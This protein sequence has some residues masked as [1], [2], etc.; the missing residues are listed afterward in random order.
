MVFEIKDQEAKGDKLK[1]SLSYSNEVL[2]MKSDLDSLKTEIEGLRQEE[3]AQSMIVPAKDEAIKQ[4]K[5]KFESDS[6]QDSQ[7]YNAAV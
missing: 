4:L 1:D 3:G 5:D 7:K 6:Q 2:V